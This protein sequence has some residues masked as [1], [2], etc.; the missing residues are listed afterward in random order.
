MANRAV[1]GV[2]SVVGVLYTCTACHRDLHLERRDGKLLRKTLC[3]C[4]GSGEP[5]PRTVDRERHFETL[6]NVLDP[7]SD[8]EAF[9]VRLIIAAE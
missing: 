1:V 4:R 8:F 7:G 2:G 6:L 5:V 9:N 3:S